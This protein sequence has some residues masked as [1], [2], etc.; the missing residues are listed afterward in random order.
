[1]IP[2]S[3]PTQSPTAGKV[4]GVHGLVAE[5]PADLRPP[6]HVAGDPVQPA[7]LFHH[8][9]PLQARALFLTDLL[10]EE[11]IPAKAFA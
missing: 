6:V 7:L 9:R 10:F 5:P 3:T 4:G 2:C 11:I 8:A 1:M